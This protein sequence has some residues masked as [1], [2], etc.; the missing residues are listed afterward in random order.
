MS[1]WGARRCCE[2]RIFSPTQSFRRL[3]WSKS[4]RTAL[5]PSQPHAAASDAGPAPAASRK[6]ARRSI[7]ARESPPIP[8]R[9][10]GAQRRRIHDEHE[11]D[12]H[13]EKPGEDPHGPEVPIPRPLESAE[14]RGEPGELRRF[15]D[16]ES[17]EDRQ[18]AQQNNGGIGELLERIV[19][20]LRRGSLA[21]AEGEILHLAR[22]PNIARPEQQRPPPA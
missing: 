12:V 11:N 4:G 9:D 1:Y 6:N 15:V 10:H 22:P 7:M 5:P 19:L 2:N 16:R 18:H 17:R 21:R 20:S 13:D 3:T 8:S 14:H